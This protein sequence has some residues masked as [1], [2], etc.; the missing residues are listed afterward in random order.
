VHE[1]LLRASAHDSAMKNAK[2]TGDF[3]AWN[4]SETTIAGRVMLNART[5]GRAGVR[6]QKQ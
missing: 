5:A 1:K 2:R 3:P 4:V 6:Q